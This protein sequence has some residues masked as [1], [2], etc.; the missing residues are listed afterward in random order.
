MRL[1]CYRFSGARFDGELPLLEEK[2]G[3]LAPS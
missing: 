2:A 1:E 3:T